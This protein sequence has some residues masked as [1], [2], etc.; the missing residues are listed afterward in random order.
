MSLMMP[1][2][3]IQIVFIDQLGEVVRDKP[4]ISFITL[5][6]GIEFLGKCISSHEKH[7]HKGGQEKTFNLA[8]NSL[9]SFQIYRQYLAPYK[10]YFYLRTGMAHAF[11]PHKHLTL[12][13]RLDQDKHLTID[14]KNRL[15]IKCEEL[16]DDFKNACKEVIAMNFLDPVD[17]MNKPILEFT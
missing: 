10:L 8:I 6:V 2:D 15:N 4:Y 14:S 3:F 9:H 12:S 1:K 5:G 16:Y 13:S 7:W 11:L 17:K